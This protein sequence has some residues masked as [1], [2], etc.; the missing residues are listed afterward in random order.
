MSYSGHVIKNCSVKDRGSACPKRWDELKPAFSDMV[1]HCDHCNKKVYLC[2]TDEQI[3]FYNSVKFCIAVPDQEGAV[4]V[5]RTPLSS[6]PSMSHAVVRAAQSDNGVVG[7]ISRPL[8]NV[9]R[10]PSSPEP[11]EEVLHDDSASSPRI[12]LI[13]DDSDIPTFLLKRSK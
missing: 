4:N 13:T 11:S 12:H 10:R 3:M 7:S 8:P 5:E 1:R 2:E 6:T 9:W